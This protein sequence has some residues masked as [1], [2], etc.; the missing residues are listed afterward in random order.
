MSAFGELEL[1]PA[2]PQALHDLGVELG[3]NFSGLDARAFG[4][5]RVRT[6]RALGAVVGVERE[7]LPARVTGVHALELLAGLVVG[8]AVWELVPLVPAQLL[9]KRES[10]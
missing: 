6:T 9:L 1:L 5:L 4:A 10:S 3:L 2:H 8:V 7:L